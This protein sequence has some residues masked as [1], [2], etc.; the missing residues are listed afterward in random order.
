MA[1]NDADPS[2]ASGGGA[3]GRVE[4]KIDSDPANVRPVRR[5]V[6]EFA[7]SAGLSQHD[8]EEIGL[9]LNE[10]LANIIRHGYGGAH[11]RPIVVTVESAQE[12][13]RLSIRDWG[14][15]FNPAQVQP[16]PV[17]EL[18]PD[19]IK[20][21]GLGL[22]CIRRLMDDVRYCALSDGMLLTMVKKVKHTER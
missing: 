13:V 10:A 3:A 11:D 19:Q 14:K 8:S 7:R 20:P 15:P 12:G 6:E 4:L 22:L 16:R 21:G 5:R 18:A 2:S 9:V 1:V 17:G